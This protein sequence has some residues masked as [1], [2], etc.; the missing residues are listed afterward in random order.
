MESYI[1]LSHPEPDLLLLRYIYGYPIRW[2]DAQPTPQQLPF[3]LQQVE[4]RQVAEQVQQVE[5]LLELQADEQEVEQQ[6][7]QAAQE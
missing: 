4:L 5:L 7:L 6:L 3:W 1:V 2:Q